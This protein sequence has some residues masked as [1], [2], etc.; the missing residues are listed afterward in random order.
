MTSVTH[1]AL[2]NAS[3]LLKLRW[4]AVV[5]QLLTIVIVGFVLKIPLFWGPLLVIIGATTVSNIFLYLW[6]SLH[7]QTQSRTDDDHGF[8]LGL[9]LVSTMDLLSLTALL[10]ATGGVSNP[11]FLFLFVNLG[12]SAI[13]LPRTWVWSLNV[14]AVFC[15]VFLLY[16]HY[17]I[18]VLESGPDL[19]PVRRSGEWSILQLGMIVAFA[20]CSSV[21]V[22]FLTRLTSSLRQH[23]LELREAQR[24]TAQNEKLEALGTLAAGTAHELA[25]PLSTIAVVAREV[26]KAVTSRLGDHEHNRELIDDIHLIRRE[27]D[28]CRKI[29]DRMSSD[30]GQTIGEA[31]Q[32]VSLDRLKTE[33]LAGLS[34]ADRVDWQTLHR[35]PT[36]TA[37]VPLMSLSQAL[38]GLIQNS[39]DASTATQRVSVEVD[40]GQS[41]TWS[42]RVQDRGQ[43]MEP[44][45]VSRV[46]QPFFTTKPPGKGMGLGVFLADNLVRRL[47]GQME[48]RSVVGIGTT[49]TIRLQNRRLSSESKET[50]AQPS[51]HTGLSERT[52]PT[53]SPKT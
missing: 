48:I 50:S 42:I 49:V 52:L 4:A 26:E 30:A 27:L 11:F 23:E 10:Y 32:A 39:L 38:R 17:S 13:L 46:G 6:V 35:G 3:W 45:T 8:D 7:S 51:E 34:D 36:A 25:T 28:R 43:G 31:M 16:D 9:G 33:T 24:L 2:V 18:A 29:L 1:R 20:G 21:V 47:G 53:R 14:L 5:G 41:S 40:C 12:L 37:L 19:Q 44:E 22:Y 15:F